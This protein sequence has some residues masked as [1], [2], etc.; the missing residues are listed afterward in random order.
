MKHLPDSP[1]FFD[2]GLYFECVRCGACCTGDPGT[3]YIGETEIP[4]IADFLGIPPQAFLKEYCYPY[5]NSYSLKEEVDGRCVF[6]ENGCRIYQVRPRQCR[7]FPFWIDHM[8]S[9]TKWEK[10]AKECPGI[11]QGRLYSKEMILAA[12][13]ESLKER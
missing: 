2:K 7:T 1:T 12:I 9:E 6:F 11:G 5:R 4:V 8:R 10:I 3:V 13:H